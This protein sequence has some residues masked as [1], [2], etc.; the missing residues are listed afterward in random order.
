M[1]STDVKSTD[2]RL[3]YLS[4]GAEPARHPKNAPVG[5]K[6]VANSLRNVVSEISLSSLPAAESLSVIA[7]FKAVIL[8]PN[9]NEEREIIIAI[10]HTL[11]FLPC[12]CCCCCV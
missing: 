4:A 3:P 10:N 2:R 9:R 12:C 5:V 1:K 8:Y 11:P 6:A 7:T